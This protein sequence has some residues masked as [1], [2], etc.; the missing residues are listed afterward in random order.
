MKK[1]AKRIASAHI[2]ACPGNGIAKFAAL[3]LLTAM[4][5][6]C[7][8]T[9][10]GSLDDGL[11]RADARNPANRILACKS[12]DRQIASQSQCLQDDAAC[13]QIASGEWCT[14]ERGN[15]CPAGSQ[16]LPVGNVCPTGSRCFRISESLECFI[17]R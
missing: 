12:T 9:G 1:Q 6:A 4:I 2:D 10:G 13:Y 11:T 7:S 8:S 17:Q 5:S 3:A 15:V 16:T 14:G